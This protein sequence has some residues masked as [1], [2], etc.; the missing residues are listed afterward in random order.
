MLDIFKPRLTVSDEL[1]KGW[2]L[3][4]DLNER[5]FSAQVFIQHHGTHTTIS[6]LVRAPLGPQTTCMD[7]H[8]AK[9]KQPVKADH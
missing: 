6:R 8:R 5:T 4:T 1:Q 7:H 9:E 2:N 3:K